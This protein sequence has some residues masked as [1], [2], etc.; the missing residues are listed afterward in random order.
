MSASVIFVTAKSEAEARRLGRGLVQDRLAAAVNIL[1]GLGSF[2]WWQGELREAD[3]A[4]LLVKTRADL[5]DQ[6]AARIKAEH[7]YACPSILALPVEAGNQDYL[8]WIEQE[9]APG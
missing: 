8:D 6:V 7:A 2:Y 9:T 3:E 5:V 1:P 4:L